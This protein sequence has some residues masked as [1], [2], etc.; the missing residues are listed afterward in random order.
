MIDENAPTRKHL[1]NALEHLAAVKARR[2]A[3]QA[4]HAFWQAAHAREGA[5]EPA[6]P[7]TEGTP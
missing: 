5:A 1:R 3:A 4:L 6:E 7:A 2:E